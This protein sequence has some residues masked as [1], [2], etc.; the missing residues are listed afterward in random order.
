MVKG[1]DQQAGYV[2]PLAYF[3]MQGSLLYYHTNQW[4]QPCDLLVVPRSKVD[5]VMH[6]APSHSL[7]GHLEAHNTFTKQ[8][9]RFHWPGMEDKVKNLFQNLLFSIVLD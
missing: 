5:I 1:E 3:L 6:L 7:R 2:L 8:R 9:D 4:G